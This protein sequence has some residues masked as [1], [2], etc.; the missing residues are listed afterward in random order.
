MRHHH[1]TIAVRGAVFGLALLLPAALFA[2]PFIPP[3][4]NLAFHLQA[5]R[6]VVVDGGAVTDWLDQTA[7]GIDFTTITGGPGLS[8]NQLNGLPALEFSG[9]KMVN[10][11]FKFG[12]DQTVFVVVAGEDVTSDGQRYMG[13]YNDGQLRFKNGYLHGWFDHPTLSPQ[14]PNNAVTAGEFALATYQFNSGN[15]LVSADG[16]PFETLKASAPTFSTG[17]DLAIGAVGNQPPSFDGRIA[18]VLVYDKALNMTEATEV[19]QYLYN[20]YVGPVRPEVIPYATTNTDPQDPTAVL[21]HFNG[22]G[23]DASG[24][25]VH[26]TRVG[27]AAHD[28]WVDGPDG[29]DLA[30]GPIDTADRVLRRQGLSAQEA[31]AFDTDTFTIEAWVRNP[32]LSTLPAADQMALFQY[33]DGGDS[34][35]DFVLTP[36]N[37]FRLHMIRDDNGSFQFYN[38]SSGVTFEDDVWY[39]MALTYDD[40]GSDST[41]DSTLRF[42]LTPLD[43]FTGQAVLVDELTGVADIRA[44]T[45]GGV[46]HI[47]AGDGSANRSFGGDIDQLRYVNRALLPHEFNLAMPAPEPG[48][49]ML[50]L[51]ALAGLAG[52]RGRRNRA[53]GKA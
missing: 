44:L 11:A 32:T 52:M 17:S 2:A 6:G 20:K 3:A 24:N 21:Y 36:D 30:T 27:G 12:V 42:Y 40:N 47:G 15:V 48:S 14:E 16:N 5:N 19:G 13:H 35:V 10:S 26:L 9:D 53:S 34:R 25:N 28:V 29:L 43:D 45:G 7:A 18:E 51:L 41:N 4:D 39:H 33:R 49:A 8:A 23:L 46:L 31:G 50:A 38:S 37:E 22:D 1:P